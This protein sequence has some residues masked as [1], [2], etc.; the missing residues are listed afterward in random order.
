MEEGIRNERFSSGARAVGRSATAPDGERFSM[1]TKSIVL[2]ATI[3][4]VSL[5]DSVRLSPALTCFLLLY[6]AACGQR[7]MAFK[8]LVFYAA[9][10]GAC[11]ALAYGKMTVIVFS[12]VHFYAAIKTYPIMVA[13]F[14]V[15]LSPPGLISAALAK[16][17]IPKRLIVG[18]LVP[19]VRSSFRRLSESCKRRGV[20]SAGN[21]ARSPVQAL[22]HALVPLMFSL[23]DSSDRLSAS[24]IARAAEAPTRRTSYYRSSFGVADA[25]CLT[26]V[27]TALAACVWV[28]RGGWFG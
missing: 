15:A 4:T 27:A 5:V 21:V 24:A 8:M 28:V 19:T 16:A 6:L 22:E 18:V 13:F 1:A 17:R 11:L 26:A 12:P 25:V 14:A 23:V 20:L 7:S 9:L 3:A 10:W 2:A